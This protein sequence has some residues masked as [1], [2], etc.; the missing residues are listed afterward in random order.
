[1]NSAPSSDRPRLLVID[2]DR[3]LCRLIADYLD[4][5]GYDVTAVHTGPEG[6]E[7]AAAEPWHAVILDYMLPG[8]DGFEVL[9]R[10]RHSSEVPVL[11]LT[12]RGDEADRIVGLELG[13]DDYLPKTFS[14][15]ELLARLR[16]VTRRPAR[17]RPADRDDREIVVGPLRLQPAAR[18]AVL[19]DRPLVLTPVEYDML[20]S[21]ARAKGRVKTRD[22]L[23]EEIR[24]REYEVFDRSVDVH[25]SALRRKLGDDPKTPH[26]IRTVR[27]A[28]YMLINPDAE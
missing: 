21:L 18:T 11:M 6:V 22:H 1:M 20:L 25:I 4:P 3:K 26:F 14:T 8:L 2:D 23:L 27:S 15:R 9:K 19:G 24:D 5:L 7:R 17:A 10:I 13:A 16:A 28:G 12:A